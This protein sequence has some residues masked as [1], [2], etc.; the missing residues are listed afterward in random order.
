MKMW[1]THARPEPAPRPQPCCSRR[2]A[3]LPLD[4]TGDKPEHLVAFAREHDWRMA[5][6]AVPRLPYTLYGGAAATADPER[7]GNTPDRPACAGALPNFVNVLTGERVQASNGDR[8]SCRE[9]FAHFPVALL[10][11]G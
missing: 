5:I 7:W 2:A 10:I 1:T 4:G 6:T 3:T 11:G 9:I 8:C